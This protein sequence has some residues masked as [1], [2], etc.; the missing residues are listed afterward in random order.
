MAMQ[1]NNNEALRQKLN[2]HMFVD[3][4]DFFINDTLFIEAAS[5]DDYTTKKTNFFEQFVLFLQFFFFFFL[6]FCKKTYVEMTYM[7]FTD[8][9]IRYFLYK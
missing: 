9:I 5:T 1:R 4:S 8:R 3:D 2:S 6:V 7:H